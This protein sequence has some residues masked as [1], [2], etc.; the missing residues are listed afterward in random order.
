[1]SEAS[2]NKEDFDS[3]EFVRVFTPQHIPTYL[4]E[5]V[6]DRDYTVEQ[7]YNYQEINCV[8][9][10][11]NGP[12]LNPLNLLY[13]I[14]NKKKVTKGFCWMVIDPLTKDLV[15]NT[16]SM[17]HDYWFKGKAVKL[18]HDKVK[19]I[20]R[21]CHLNKVY[22]ITKYPKH[23]ER[24]GFKPSKHILMEYVEET[25]DG[26]N[27]QSSPSGPSELKQSAAEPVHQ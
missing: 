9:N 26:A 11:E 2:T 16:Y 5:Q 18:L 13:V 17:D 6:K 20:I 1:M 25:K 3:L 19:E 21:D 22:W 14:V 4:V 12:V 10:T 15:V 8:R 23:S 24:Y 27:I 7:F